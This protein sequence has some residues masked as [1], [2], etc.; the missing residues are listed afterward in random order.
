MIHIADY[1]VL[2]DVGNTLVKLLREQLCPYP[3]S[4]PE[5]I[6]IASPDEKGDLS[7][8]LYL[9]NISENG[10]YRQTQMIKRGTGSQQFPPLMLN[11]SYLMIA[12]SN[13]EVQSKAIDEHLI[14]GRAMQVIY[15]NS[16]LRGS[17]L[18]GSLASTDDELRVVFDVIA[19]DSMRDLW[20]FN[21][22][23]FKLCVSFTVSPAQMDSTR[24][25]ASS[26]VLERDVQMQDKEQ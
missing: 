11:L 24:I 2:A 23:S 25:K 10:E 12:Y 13:A 22:V 4:Q 14:L 7:L 8:C 18:E 19:A 9:Y 17:M 21:D 1:T 3:I 26:R 15:D 20:N 16:V 5:H 6:G